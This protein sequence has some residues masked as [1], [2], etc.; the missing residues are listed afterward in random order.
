MVYKWKYIHYDESLGHVPIGVDYKE[1]YIWSPQSPGTDYENVTTEEEAISHEASMYEIRRS[2]G[3]YF[4]DIMNARLILIGQI[5]PDKILRKTVRSYVYDM[6]KL[7]RL[8]VFEGLWISAQRE[9]EK[10]KP[11][12]VLQALIDDNDLPIYQEELISE[13]SSRIDLAI[14]ELYEG[15]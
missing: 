13:I 10:V 3:V 12:P 14:E 15:E 11:N 2:Q 4:S 6:F 9:I 5:I 8:E 7:T 1:P